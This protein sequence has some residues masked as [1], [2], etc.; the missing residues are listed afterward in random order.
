MPDPEGAPDTGT[1]VIGP[2]RVA[3]VTGAANGIGRALAAAFVAAG[4]TAV[5]ADVDGQEAEAVAEGLR[6]DGGRALAVT[7]DVSDPES[8]S[9]LATTTVDRFGRVDVLCNNAGVSTFNLI[10]DQTLDDWHW[11]FG[12]NLWG[13]VHGLASFLPILRGQPTPSHIVNTASMGGL[14]SGIP[15]IGPYAA[16]KTAVVSISETLRQECAA[17]GLPIG[18]SVLCPSATDTRVMESERNRPTALGA[19]VGSNRAR[20]VLDHPEPRRVCDRRVSLRRSARELPRIGCRTRSRQRASIVRMRPDDPAVGPPSIGVGCVNFEAVPRDKAA[21]LEKMATFIADARARGCDLVIFPELALNTWGRCDACAA[22]HR[23]CEWHRGQAESANGPASQAVVEMAATHGVHV[24]YGFEEA[25]DADATRIYNAANVVAPDGL[26]GTY[27][28]LHLGV[29]LETDRFTPGDAIPVFETALGP[30]GVS[31]CYDFYQGPELSRILALKGARLIVNPT[32][33]GALPRSRQHLEQVTAVR[34]HENLVA[35]AS[36][37]RVGVS[38][39]TEWAGGSVI[40]A[41]QFPGFPVTLARAEGDEGVIA[42]TLDFAAIAEWYDV[43]P[44]REW[45]AGP[46]RRL[47]QL[48]AD[49]LAALS[50]PEPDPNRRDRA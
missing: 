44:W 12:V 29:P 17:Y 16:S 20:G 21:T 22:R 11:V 9:Q 1:S 45:R 31:I 15:F 7:V 30:I 39:G 3:V 26:V 10:Q 25:G 4:S 2:G 40:C 50:K 24:I 43:L 5:V 46:Q 18:V 8:V 36:A 19:E 49:E 13:V 33:R 37:N 48:I 14:M 34:A 42:A 27:R 38:H 6:V 47:G 23:P 41:P 35:A 32:G 28:K